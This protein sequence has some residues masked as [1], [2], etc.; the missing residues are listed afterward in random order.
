MRPQPRARRPCAQHGEVCCGRSQ[1]KAN[2]EAAAA[3]AA[4]QRDPLLAQHEQQTRLEVSGR[5]ECAQLASSRW[6]AL[7]G[8][9]DAVPVC[10]PAGA[11]QDFPPLPI[12]G[13]VMQRNEGRWDFTLRESDNG[14]ELGPG[15]ADD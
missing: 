7:L 5:V 3:K 4:A 10:C 8:D 9:P 6:W 15:V 11:L 12:D 13:Q 1:E 14:C 2:E